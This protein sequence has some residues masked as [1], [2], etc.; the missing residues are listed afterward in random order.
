MAGGQLLL[1]IEQGRGKDSWGVGLRERRDEKRMET[2]VGAG[3]SHSLREEA[4]GQVPL[5]MPA[6][7]QLQGIP[8]GQSPHCPSCPLQVTILF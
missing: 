2:G 6:S 5:Q 7:L 4:S 1:N 8:L 3:Q